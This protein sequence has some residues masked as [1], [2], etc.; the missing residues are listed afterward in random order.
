[1]FADKQT[2]IETQADVLI[3]ILRSAPDS[4]ESE[5]QSLYPDGDQDRH[6]NLTVRS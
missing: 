6:Q 5:K 1:M 4:G 2:D 3:T